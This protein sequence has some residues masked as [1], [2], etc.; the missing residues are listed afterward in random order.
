MIRR[1]SYQILT[2]AAPED[3]SDEDQKLKDELDMLVERISVR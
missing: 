1:A 3:L 2:P